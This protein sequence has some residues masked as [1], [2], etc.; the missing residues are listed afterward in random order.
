MVTGG[1]RSEALTVS[2]STPEESTAT[3]VFVFRTDCTNWMVLELV[4]GL[5]ACEALL[6]VAITF[7]PAALAT[8]A[9]GPEANWVTSVLAPPM[10]NFCNVSSGENT[11]TLRL[12]ATMDALKPSSSKLVSTSPG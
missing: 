5:A 3:I 12:L 11:Y 1:V 9:K 8:K 4:G 2:T 10:L 7:K 6:H